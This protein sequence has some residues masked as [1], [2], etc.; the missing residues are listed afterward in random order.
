M[1]NSYDKD[2]KSVNEFLMPLICNDKKVKLM[3]SDIQS[4]G[5]LLVEIHKEGFKDRYKLTKLQSERIF[6]TVKLANTIK[7]LKAKEKK[8]QAPE[9]V[10]EY[11][12]EDMRYLKKEQFKVARL[13][14]K[15]NLIGISTVSLGSL[16]Q[17]LVHPREVFSDAI[18]SGTAS[19][20]LIH[21]HPSG[22]TEPS[23]ADITLTKRLVESG[24]ILGI[25]VVDHIII[26]N[27]R[28]CSFLEDG[29]M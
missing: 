29:Y 26:G 27:G 10:A 14:I 19:I 9:T 21:N 22:N 18:K 20:I 4:I 1:E 25:K 16:G 2:I 5:D 28:Y 12:M 23:N 24:E 6:N 3:V 8:M 7:Y 11:V 17:T 13:N 15:S